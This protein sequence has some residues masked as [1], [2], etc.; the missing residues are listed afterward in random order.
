MVVYLS[1]KVE[2]FA[3]LGLLAVSLNLYDGC[4]DVTEMAFIDF[5]G[6]LL[7]SLCRIGPIALWRF[8]HTED[9]P[10]VT[11]TDPDFTELGTSLLVLQLID[12]KDLL[13]L[14]LRESKLLSHVLVA[15]L[16]LRLVKQDGYIGIGDNGLFQ[17]VG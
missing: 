15:V 3:N 7:Q 11:T 10:G 12:G 1:G 8:L 17:N 9:I 2:V 6:F 5:Q 16:E 13:K 4:L 14:Y